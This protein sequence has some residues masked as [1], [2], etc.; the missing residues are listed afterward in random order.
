MGQ[1]RSALHEDQNCPMC[2]SMSILP[3]VAGVEVRLEFMA[4]RGLS[5]FFPHCPLRG[6][7]EKPG[8]L[9]GLSSVYRCPGKATQ[10]KRPGPAGWCSHN[11]IHFVSQHA[12]NLWGY[13]FAFTK[14]KKYK[15]QAGYQM[16]AVS[17]FCNSVIIL[18]WSGTD[19]S[20]AVQCVVFRWGGQ[21]HAAGPAEV[22]PSGTDG[23]KRSHS[24]PVC[25][26]G[27]FYPCV[28]ITA[29]E[30]SLILWEVKKLSQSALPHHREHK[31]GEMRSMEY[32]AQKRDCQRLGERWRGLRRLQ[33]GLFLTGYTRQDLHS[34]CRGFW[35]CDGACIGVG[36]CRRDCAHQL[37]APW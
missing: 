25:S 1:K 11:L 14:K 13:R 20:P 3:L 7:Q 31:P 5:H 9:P 2:I 29:S 34:T 4:P 8:E 6:A 36:T 10:R 27:C 21:P 37:G 30:F 24:A 23:R 33:N 16:I 12:T 17:Q 35:G 28:E 32:N 15:N 18:F 26:L 22:Q 19:T